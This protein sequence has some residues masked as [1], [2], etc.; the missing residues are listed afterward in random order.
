MSMAIHLSRDLGFIELS[1]SGSVIA[2]IPGMF[3]PLDILLEVWF[4]HVTMVFFY[5]KLLLWTMI[6]YR[7]ILD[8]A[9]EYLCGVSIMRMKHLPLVR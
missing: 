9:T 1:I 8:L 4:E 3:M 7:G 2:D 6:F 5:V